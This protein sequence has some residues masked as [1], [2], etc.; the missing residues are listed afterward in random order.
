MQDKP[1]I[2][3]EKAL[4]PDIHQVESTV[5][6]KG[7]VTVSW[8]P[9]NSNRTPTILARTTKA[10]RYFCVGIIGLTSTSNQFS[11]AQATQIAFWL[12]ALILFLGALD[13]FIG[14]EPDKTV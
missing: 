6:E 11:A 9:F 7:K 14:I 13:V 8:N 12:A 5:V 10:L 3:P 2:E 1:T 4:P